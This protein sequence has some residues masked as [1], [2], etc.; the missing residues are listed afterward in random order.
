M[1]ALQ[2]ALEQVLFTESSAKFFAFLVSIDVNWS[3]V[4][5][6]SVPGISKSGTVLSSIAWRG[7]LLVAGRSRSVS[8][9]LSSARCG[10][11]VGRGGGFC[12]LRVV[13]VDAEVSDLLRLLVWFNMLVVRI[14][15]GGPKFTY[16]W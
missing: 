16:G 9:S 5:P 11:L 7:S 6:S 8:G 10:P 1:G 4:K 12:L 13:T 15:S 2:P 14:C 3:I